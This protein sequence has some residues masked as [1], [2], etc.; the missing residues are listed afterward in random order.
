MRKPRS[1]GDVRRLASVAAGEPS[2]SPRITQEKK[3]T[4]VNKPILISTTLTLG[5][6]ASLA[7]RSPEARANDMLNLSQDRTRLIELMPGDEGAGVAVVFTAQEDEDL[8]QGILFDTDRN[9]V[10]EV[11]LFMKE[12]LPVGA[13]VQSDRF[14]SVWGEVFI[15]GDI[16]GPR[17]LVGWIQGDWIEQDGRGQLACMI[18]DRS[19]G[20][21]MDD[22]A[23]VLEGFYQVAADGRII[24]GDGG[25]AKGTPIQLGVGGKG[26]GGSKAGGQAG[27]VGGDGPGVGVGGGGAGG[28]GSGAGSFGS[29]WDV[30]GL[31]GGFGGFGAGE[32]GPGEPDGLL[33]LRWKIFD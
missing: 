28:P 8:L 12:I 33:F 3:E 27:P 20:S 7:L 31:G 10:L 5:T 26:N 17:E 9:R 18:L 13:P 19:Q 22:L 16:S 14:G 30:D 32:L 29:N 25:D 2:G 11:E 24:I 6:L 15:P 1:E 4:P 23:G 21:E